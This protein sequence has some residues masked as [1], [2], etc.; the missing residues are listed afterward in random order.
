MGML[1]GTLSLA[2]SFLSMF[3]SNKC[4]IDHT[5]FN[6]SDIIEYDV[7]KAEFICIADIIRT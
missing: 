2:A 4:Y 1:A 7:V 6:T 5:Y 3:V